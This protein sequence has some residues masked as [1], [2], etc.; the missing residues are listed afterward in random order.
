[1]KFCV[2]PS[3][4]YKNHNKDSINEFIRNN[5]LKI[6]DFRPPVMNEDFLALSVSYDLVISNARTNY[7]Y[8]FPRFIV[9]P[10]KEIIS[11]KTL[12]AVITAFDIYRGETEK[13]LETFLTDKK[14]KVVDFRKP[15]VGDCYIMLESM[16]GSFIGI[17]KALNP[18]SQNR[19]IV[20]YL[21]DI[22]KENSFAWE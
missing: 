11:V 22:N 20:K 1:M 21:K 4:V 9:Q 16:R 2:T 10:T 19:L 12:I 17:E 7:D 15:E 18:H 8:T 5:S 14:A 3:Q 6:I 13:S